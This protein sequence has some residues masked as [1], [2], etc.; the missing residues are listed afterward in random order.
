MLGFIPILFWWSVIF[1]KLNLEVHSAEAFV[2]V[3]KFKFWKQISTVDNQIREYKKP[4]N[5]DSWLYFL[6][7]RMRMITNLQLEVN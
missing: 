7:I 5:V 3:K 6:I 2:F 1:C 4:Q